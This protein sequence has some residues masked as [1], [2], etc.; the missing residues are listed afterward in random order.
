M[1]KKTYRGSLDG[2]VSELTDAVRMLLSERSRVTVAIDGRAGAGKTTLAGA[3]VSS[4]KEQA[5]APSVTLIGC[6]GFF[7]PP[8]KRTPLRL[9][10][11]GGNM[12][13]ERLLDEVLLPLSKGQN[14]IYSG[15]DCHTLT[16]SEPIELLPTAL[17]VVEGSYA[18]HPDLI[19]FYDLKVFLDVEEEVQRERI[20]RRNKERATLFFKKWIP[21]E[22]LYFAAFSVKEH[23]DLLISLL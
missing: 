6:D 16:Y 7:L 17:T 11:I 2:A 12:E 5:D 4:L 15:F 14:G 22:E 1:K 8:E 13:R 20:I 19:G 21:M 23:A 18:H 3:F 9:E 10:E